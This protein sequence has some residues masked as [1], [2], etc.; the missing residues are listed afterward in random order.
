MGRREWIDPAAGKIPVAVCADRWI[1][2]R[3]S[4]RPRTV[5]LYQWIL[6]KHIAPILG[7]VPLNRLTTPTVRSWRVQLLSW[8]VSENGAAKAY[9]LLRAILNTAVRQDEIL[10]VNPCRI[11]GAD[12]EHAAERP[13]LTASQVI[14]P[15]K[16][17][18]ERFMALV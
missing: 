6:A 16:T 3:R 10:R 4:L 13:S 15:A 8:G 11:P 14:A 5:H 1:T 9:R 2:Q 17:G 12:H 18:R 7:S